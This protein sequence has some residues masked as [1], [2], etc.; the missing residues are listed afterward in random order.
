MNKL[1]KNKKTMKQFSCIVF[2]CALMAG[3]SGEQFA[4]EAETPVVPGDERVALAVQ[5]AGLEAE[6]TPATRAALTSGSIGIY[7]SGSGYTTLQNKRYDYS[8]GAWAPYDA[9]NTIFLGNTEASVC[10]YHPYTSSAGTVSSLPLTTQAYAANQEL[11]YAT[12]QTVSGSSRNVSFSLVRAY[13]LIRVII[14]RHATGF[15]GTCNVTTMNLSNIISNTTLNI[16]NGVQAATNSVVSNKL[17]SIPINQTLA[18]SATT[19]KDILAV[20]CTFAT[21]TVNGVSN[22]GLSIELI[23]DGKS[24]IA[25]ISRA[26]LSQLDK[27]KQYNITVTINGSSLGINSIEQ[28][29]A[30]QEVA[31][32]GGD[33]VPVP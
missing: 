9:A 2:I 25:G 23:V 28:A 7:L 31:V 15:P 20:P 3:C 11:S 27:G 19:Q 12:N 26:T 18:A 29:P 30:W 16:S 24:M 14:K 4:P 13:S 17:S 10:A 6:M 5:S 1:L 33:A 22:C 32:N 21:T 8:G